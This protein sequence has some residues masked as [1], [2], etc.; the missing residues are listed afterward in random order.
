MAAPGLPG[1]RL[2]L[3]GGGDPRAAAVFIH[4]AVLGAARSGLD[5]LA[6]TRVA[7]ATRPIFIVGCGHSGTTLLAAILHA[8]PQLAVIAEETNLFYAGRPA[9]VIAAA[10]TAAAG[11][12]PP[13]R[14]VEK[15]PKHV[16]NLGRILAIMPQAQIIVCVRDPRAVCLSLQR[17]G[18]GFL[19]ALGR[20]WLDNALAARRRRDPR[21]HLV[22]YEDLVRDPHG[23]LAALMAFLGL[24]FDERLLAFHTHGFAFAGFRR[25]AAAPPNRTAAL[26]RQ[27]VARPLS[28]DA[29]ERWRTELPPWQARLVERLT[30]PLRR[31]LGYAD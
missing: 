12:G 5:R 3:V 28:L 2:A 15:T 14:V 24:P 7:T 22:R 17:R 4:K 19:R 1:A 23:E 25:S 11:A 10:L 26:R 21:C 30:R 27:Q 13:C 18:Y 29:L 20:W 9:R 6:G 16:R 8:H 31:R